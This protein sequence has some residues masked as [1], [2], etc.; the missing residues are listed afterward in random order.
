MERILDYSSHPAVVEAGAEAIGVM[1]WH[2]SVTLA[3]GAPGLRDKLAAHV[4]PV[5]TSAK[6]GVQLAGLPGM[7][8]IKT[9]EA[10]DKAATMEALRIELGLGSS[11]P[12]PC[13]RP[14]A[15]PCILSFVASLPPE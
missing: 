4:D 1:L 10:A 12:P 11:A 9:E 5:A 14:S 3:A 2:D 7:V 13:L 8:E 15:A 6:L